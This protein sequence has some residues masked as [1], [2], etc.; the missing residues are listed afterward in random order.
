M[1]LKPDLEL[2]RAH[3]G[4]LFKAWPRKSSRQNLRPEHGLPFAA[5]TEGG[6]A[7]GAPGFNVPRL[8]WHVLAAENGSPSKFRISSAAGGPPARPEQS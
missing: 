8:S 6:H 3:G 2:V 1:G 4:Q 7:G 5:T